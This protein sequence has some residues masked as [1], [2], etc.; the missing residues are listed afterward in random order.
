MQMRLPWGLWWRNRGNGERNEVKEGHGLQED[1]L[2]PQCPL[3]FVYTL[4]WVVGCAR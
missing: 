4:R 1:V 2:Y 3:V